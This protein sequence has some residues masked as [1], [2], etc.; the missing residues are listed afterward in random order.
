MCGC[1]ER[2][3]CSVPQYGRGQGESGGAHTGKTHTHTG[4]YTRMLHLPFS[5]LPLSQEE[6]GNAEQR[7]RIVSPREHGTD[8]ATTPKF[9]ASP[10]CQCQ[11]PAPELWS[12]T[13][14]SRSTSG[15]S[16]TS[17]RSTSTDTDDS[18]D[19]TESRLAGRKG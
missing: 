2:F 19:P 15:T 16:S 11:D 7:W 17:S 18:M 13:K 12:L 14:G 8:P 6:A 3:C 5:D 4:T 9:T 10:G 1:G